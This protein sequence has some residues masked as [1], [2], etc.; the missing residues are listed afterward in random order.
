MNGFLEFIYG[1][2]INILREQ[3]PH[4]YNTFTKSVAIKQDISTI[5]SIIS[6]FLLV[7]L[8]LFKV[9]II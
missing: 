8:L 9:I 6:S 4:I 7:L 1:T 2:E 3:L 5:K